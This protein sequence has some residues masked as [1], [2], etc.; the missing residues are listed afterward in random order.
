MDGEIL[1]MRWHALIPT[2]LRR[3]EPTWPTI[4]VAGAVVVVLG[5]LATGAW[6]WHAAQVQRGNSAYGAALMRARPGETP[7]AGP[8]VKA[9][10]AAD[11]ERALA[12][13]PSHPMAGQAAYTLGNLRFDVGQYD[14][15]RAAWQIAAAKSSPGTVATLARAGIGY[16]WEAERKFAEAGRVFEEEAARLK[17]AD[18][19]YEEVL[20]DLARVQELSGKKDAAVATYRRILKDVPKTVRAEE[21]RSQLASLGAAP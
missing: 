14:K 12:D 18:F 4:I 8:E 5:L 20:F 17:P 1:R 11:L 16:A 19:Y 6:L 10:A 3:V 15:A 21:V 9:T 7:D 13:Y 2:G